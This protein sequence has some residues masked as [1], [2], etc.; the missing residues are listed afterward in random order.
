MPAL[1]DHDPGRRGRVGS[2]DVYWT[3]LLTSDTPPSR[4]MEHVEPGSQ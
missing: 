3:K 4:D 1:F 2:E